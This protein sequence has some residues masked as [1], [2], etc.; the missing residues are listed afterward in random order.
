VHDPARGGLRNRRSGTSDNLSV[1]FRASTDVKEESRDLIVGGT[2]IQVND[3][4][5]LAF[6]SINK[7]DRSRS[8]CGPNWILTAAHCVDAAYDITAGLGAHNVSYVFDPV[9]EPGGKLHFISQ[10]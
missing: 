9:W 1:L 4:P 3:Y 7:S 5:Y 6:L 10:G 2:E 8:F